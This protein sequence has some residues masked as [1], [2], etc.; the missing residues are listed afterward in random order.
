MYWFSV[1]PDPLVLEQALQNPKT[2]TGL[3]EGM[4]AR[5]D[6]KLKQVSDKMDGR[7]AQMDAKMDSRFAQM[8]KLAQNRPDEMH[9]C[10][11]LNLVHWV[12]HKHLVTILVHTKC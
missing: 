2:S 10:T 9:Y 8:D 5:L 12:G 11:Q 6:V 7:F 4:D 1:L 3:N